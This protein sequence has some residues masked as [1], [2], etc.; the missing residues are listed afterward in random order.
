VRKHSIQQ[1][2]NKSAEAWVD[3]VRTGKDNCRYYMNNP[4]MFRMLGKI[5]GKKVLDLGCGEGF[6]TRMMA[7][8]GAEVTG[9]DFAEKMLS[10]AKD[11]EKRDRLGIKYYICNATKLSIFKNSTFDIVS[12]FMTIQDIANYRQA[13]KEVNRVLKKN[14]R[15]VIGTTHPCFEKTLYRD[16]RYHR[17][18]RYFKNKTYKLY[19]KMKRLTK[20]FT[21]TSFHRTL[22]EYSD[23]LHK[24][25]FVISRIIEP[26]PTKKGLKIH[27][28]LD[29]QLLFPQS[30]VIEMIKL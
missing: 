4:A 9:I 20:H 17:D 29:E 18:E 25:G 8:R 22:T 5:R 3:F 30:I 19:W 11:S 2:W 7:R 23:A 6:N 15:L 27:P 10:L 14:G 26:K 24:A 21:T 13:L 28:N 1:E 16:K 12:S